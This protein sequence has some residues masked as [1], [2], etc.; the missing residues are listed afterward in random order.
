MPQVNAAPLF[1]VP[2]MNATYQQKF[3]KLQRI[4]KQADVNNMTPLQAIQF[5]AKVKD[6]L[7]E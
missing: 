5:L 2:D 3:E 7:G 4:I 1:S 6:E